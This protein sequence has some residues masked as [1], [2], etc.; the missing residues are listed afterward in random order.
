MKAYHTLQQSNITTHKHHRKWD[1][2]FP[3]EVID[4]PT[5]STHPTNNHNLINVRFLLMHGA[6]RI[7]T[8]ARH[9]L[10]DID[11]SCPSCKQECNDIHL[12]LE[13]P[14]TKQAWQHVENIWQSLQQKHS[15]LQQYQIKKSY[16]LFGPPSITPRNTQEKYI[17][18]FLDII[19]GHMQTVIWNS[20]VNKIYQNEEYTKTSIIEKFNA[21]IRKSLQCFL[22]A[23]KSKEFVPKRWTGS[24]SF[25]TKMSQEKDTENIKLTTIEFINLTTKHIDKNKTHEKATPNDTT[26]D[27]TYKIIKAQTDQRSITNRR[28]RKREDKTQSISE[29]DKTMEQNKTNKN[30]VKQNRMNNAK[31]TKHREKNKNKTTEKRKIDKNKETKQKTIKKNRTKRKSTVNAEKATEKS[32]TDEKPPEQSKKRK[33]SHLENVDTKRIKLSDTLR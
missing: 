3:G 25:L 24:T 30:A 8:Q 21:N 23:M 26:K 11:L 27:E 9:W 28:K 31:P 16:K 10:K 13:C 7:G 20:Y 4:W 15:T 14:T 33:N 22:H 1:T 29:R 6:I 19:L 17:Y 12:F 2:H 18:T 32:K 5:L